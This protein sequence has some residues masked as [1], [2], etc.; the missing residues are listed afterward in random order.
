MAHPHDSQI[1]INGEA[2]PL[3]LTL[4]ALAQ[5]ETA[6]GGGD[7]EALQ[8]R[9][10]KPSV[11][12]MIAILHALLMG[13]GAQ[14]PLAV[15]KASDVDLAEAARAIASAFSALAHQGAPGDAALQ[16][17]PPQQEAPG[18]SQSL[19]K[20]SQKGAQQGAPQQAV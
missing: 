1:V 4:G 15:L 18:K 5:I 13:A 2:H 10:A 6:L 20:G 14:M 11:S 19:Q 9:L 16:P 7:F 8:A 17:A 3:R 12:D